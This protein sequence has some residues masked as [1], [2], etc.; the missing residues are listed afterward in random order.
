MGGSRETLVVKLTVEVLSG[1]SPYRS[2]QSES[3][4]SPTVGSVAPVAGQ[5]LYRY[6][7]M[8]KVMPKYNSLEPMSVSSLLNI[9]RSFCH[10]FPRLRFAL[11][12]KNLKTG[13]WICGMTNRSVNHPGNDPR[14]CLSHSYS[15]TPTPVNFAALC[16][17][18][19]CA[20]LSP[21]VAIR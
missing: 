6:P 8:R 15:R 9:R 3:D 1:I 12:R 19:R 13:R 10:C 11:Q 2:I 16:L 20:L 4:V 5:V 7:V 17:C 21:S 18:M 14:F